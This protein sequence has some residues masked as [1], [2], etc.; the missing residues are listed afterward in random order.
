M[1]IGPPVGGSLYE[2]FGFRGPYIFVVIVAFGDLIGRLLVIERKDALKY[3]FDPMEEVQLPVKEPKRKS[4]DTNDLTSS[5]TQTPAETGSSIDPSE[6]TA[7]ATPKIEPH[8]PV[9]NVS[10]ANQVQ[11]SFATVMVKLLLTPRA[12]AAAFMAFLYGYGTSLIF[13]VFLFAHL[14]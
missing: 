8:M 13:E 10:S 11:L 2:R 4:G 14:L 3:G 9:D 1:V 6:K 12:M 5:S 7:G